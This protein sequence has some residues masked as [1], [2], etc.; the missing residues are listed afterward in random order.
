MSFIVPDRLSRKQV[1]ALFL[2]A[3]LLAIPFADFAIA[4]HDP[5]E[6]LL[7]MTRGFLLPDFGAVDEIG[8]ALLLTIMFAVAGVAAGAS[9]GLILAPFYQYW[10]VRSVCIFLRSIHEL[11]WALVL[12]QAI[13]IGA[14]TGVLAIA[15]PYAGIFAK[16]FAEYLE[17][18]DP[19]PSQA[20]PAGVGA[21]SRFLYARMP[22]V[23]PQI[24]T[25]VLYR[26]E[27]GLR[28]SAVLGFIGLP[29]LGFQLDTFFRQGDYGAASAI[30]IIYVALIASIRIWMH[31]RLVP[32]WIVAAFVTLAL[33][34]S[35][36]MGQGA[37]WRFLTIDIVPSPLRG[38]W[39]MQGFI[40]W[41][42]ELMTNQA[43]PGIVATLICAQIALVLTGAIAIAGFGLLVPRVSSRMV[44]FVVHIGLVILRSIPEYLLAY[45]FLQA[46]GPSMLPAV[47]ALALHN[48]AIIAHLL[49]RQGEE[50]VA[51]LRPDAPRGIMLLAYELTPRLFGQFLALCLYRWEI[52]LRETA[53][54]GL[55]G[56]ATLGFFVDAAMSEL[57]I[58]RVVVLLLAGALLIAMVD[59]LSRFVRR[60]LA[61]TR[62][63]TR[64]T[65]NQTS[66][67]L[68]VRSAE[69][70]RHHP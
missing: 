21:L 46:F 16:V 1:V 6:A 51:R 67:P 23:L 4:D 68:G 8:K 57:R 64:P 17:E 48:G 7:R 5:W 31:W 55:L 12:M 59:A 50:M 26:L 44:R 25:Y 33:I 34:P 18:A 37:L 45:L 56:V 47:L 19:R 63:Q 61:L 15:L 49:G 54:M 65:G 24:R 43:L 66:R 29:T 58:D 14:P 20:L 62:L 28:S 27:C 9:V 38:G 42:S 70:L 52:I 32:V 35:P 41:L 53:V 11:F 39:D 69:A 30:L 10:P 22:L 60:R 36:P 40:T 3:A 13:G 2:V